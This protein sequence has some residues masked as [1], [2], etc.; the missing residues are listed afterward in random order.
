MPAMK[1]KGKATQAALK[2]IFWTLI[3]L[4]ALTMMGFMAALV[5]TFIFTMSIGLFGLWALFS[6]FCLWFFRDPDPRVPPDTNVIV[7]PAHGR[8]DVIDEA[9]ESEF[10]GAPC[11][12]ISIFL[13]VVEVH[14]QKAPVTGKVG[15]LKHTTG[16]FVNA[17]KQESAA[18]NENVLIGLESQERPGERIAV[19]L[20][21]GV[22]ARRIVPWIGLGDEVA[23]GERISLIQFGSRVDLYLP[24]NTEVRVKLGD[25]VRGGETVIAARK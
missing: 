24:L 5:G 16:E 12:R 7:A 8:V 18:H 15:H 23:R 4:L 25:K 1:H 19:R 13:S 6:L 2:L 17:L 10:V 9:T 3:I 11:R 14:V 20:I 22:L 21:A